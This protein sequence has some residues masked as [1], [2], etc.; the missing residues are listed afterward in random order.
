MHKFYQLTKSQLRIKNS[1]I[2][3]N[4]IGKQCNEAIMKN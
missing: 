1:K 2:Q 3:E 4:G